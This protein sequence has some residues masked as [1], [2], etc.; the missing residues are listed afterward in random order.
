MKPILTASLVAF[1]LAS[2]G[3]ARAVE[4][5]TPLVGTTASN[6][7]QCQVTNVGT[8]ATAVT[9]EL[10]DYFGFQ[11][12]PGFNDC[13]SAPLAP[14]AT[15]SVVAAANTDVYCLINSGSRRIR[16]ALAVYD[17]ATDDLIATVCATR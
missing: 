6:Y 4:F 11:V 8:T 7:A 9:V 14:R 12:I 2:H 10:R 15:C 13:N 16:A 17:D 5:A 1:L 3:S